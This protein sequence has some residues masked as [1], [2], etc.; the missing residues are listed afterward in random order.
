MAAGRFRPAPPPRIVGQGL[1]A[2]Q[3]A[4]DTQRKG[5]S[6]AKIVVELP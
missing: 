6:A 3:T 2:V 1:R 4:F 5:V